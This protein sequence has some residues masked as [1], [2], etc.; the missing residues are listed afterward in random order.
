MTPDKE[1]ITKLEISLAHLQ[2]QYEILNEVIVEQSKELDRMRKQVQKWER[3][4]ESLKHRL[5]GPSEPLD[6]KPPHY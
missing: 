2:R 4:V 3:A 1:R 6:D 5:D